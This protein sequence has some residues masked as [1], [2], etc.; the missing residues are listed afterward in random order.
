VREAFK[1]LENEW[2]RAEPSF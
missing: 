2:G 1:Q